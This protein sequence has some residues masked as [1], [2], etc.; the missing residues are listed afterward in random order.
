MAGAIKL[1][2]LSQGDEPVLSRWVG[3]IRHH[4]Y[5]H[6]KGAEGDLTHAKRRQCEG[7]A[8]RDLKTLAL[9]TGVMQPQAK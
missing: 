7:R 1:R 8:E 9:K 5:P 4:M 6:K 2:L 3:P